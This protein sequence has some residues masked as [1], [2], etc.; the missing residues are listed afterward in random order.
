MYMNKRF[1]TLHR[2]AISQLRPH[3]LEKDDF[4]HIQKIKK[5]EYTN[6]I[7][8]KVKMPKV[9]L[10]T[11]G[12]KKPLH[13]SQSPLKNLVKLIKQPN[14][15]TDQS[16]PP[17]IY[18]KKSISKI[19][20]P[21]DC[22]KL[23]VFPGN[24]MEKS[25]IHRKNVST[26][27]SL[28]LLT[29]KNAKN[30]EKNSDSHS[31]Y[32]E[33]LAFFI[34]KHLDY[35]PIYKKIDQEKKGFIDKY[36]IKNYFYSVS[37]NCNI[38]ELADSLLAMAKCISNEPVI[39]KN[40]FFALCSSIEYDVPFSHKTFIGP[41]A[42]K[43]SSRVLYLKS[44]FQEFTDEDQIK[45]SDLANFCGILDKDTKKALDLI[46]TEQVDFSRFLIC[47]P[48]FMWLRAIGI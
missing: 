32:F 30:A 23:I 18:S 9:H 28:P 47:L 20:K 4:I 46:T 25:K 37:A 1:N 3:N 10:D 29:K 7:S 41:N 26:Q 22:I 35:G 39:S 21:H 27:E 44:I 36:D 38:E 6:K 33:L 43:L 19:Q 45:K 8:I 48:F 5:I 24:L 16:I 13:L 40:T 12:P 17:T 15:L 42:E 31:I 14:N 2:R 11:K 34:K